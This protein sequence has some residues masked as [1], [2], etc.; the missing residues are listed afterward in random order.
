MGFSIWVADDP[1]LETEEPSQY[2]HFSATNR[3]MLALRQE[4]DAQGMLALIHGSKSRC[5]CSAN[6]RN[7][8]TSGRSTAAC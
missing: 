4:M 8:R 7:G 2:P 3:E 1:E 5:V 6:G